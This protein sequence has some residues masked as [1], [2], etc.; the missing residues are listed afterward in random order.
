MTGRARQY[1][2]AGALAVAVVTGLLL[3]AL[4][5]PPVRSYPAEEPRPVISSAGANGLIGRYE[6][7]GIMG[8]DTVLTAYGN[9]RESETVAD[10][11]L[12]GEDTLRRVEAM[13]SVHLTSSELS[14]FNSAPVG[15]FVKLSPEL[16]NVLRAA[17]QLAKDSDG[18]FDVT[19]R[20]LIEL[21]K[22]TR[23]TKQLPTDA[24]IEAAKAKTGWEHI[25]LREDGAVRVSG[26]VSVDLGGIAKGYGIDRAV[27]AM[28][29]AGREAGV[30]EVGGDVRFFGRKPDG[31]PW[32]FSVRD[33]FGPGVFD[34]YEME[35][36]AVCTS[37]NYERGSTIGGKRYSHIIDPRTG[38]PA[39]A[40][41]SVTVVA[42]TAMI[43]DGWATALSVL[44]PAGLE[45]LPDGVEA[46]LI[47]GGPDDYEVVTTEGFMARHRAGAAE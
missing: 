36:G 13:M 23:R 8:T 15:E 21:W 35:A 24:A 37:G 43:A 4:V 42:A 9:A 45:L 12:A 30:V 1:L 27:D 16:M 5:F 29:R 10:S 26:D 19:V 44:G 41:P 47:V 39:E 38:W 20:P 46:M 18:A 34:T 31:A 11:L 3:R 33:P 14:V 28:Q 7:I 32:T 6:P 2:V 17:K 22:L 25:E 40:A